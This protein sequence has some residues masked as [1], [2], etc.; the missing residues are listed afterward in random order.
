MS[1][2][3]GE[4]MTEQPEREMARLTSDLDVDV[5]VVGGGLAGLG[6]AIEAARHGA[7]VAVLE[8]RRLGYGASGCHLGTVMPGFDVPLDD[9]IAR[10]GIEN[11]SA[12]WRLSQQGADHVRALASPMPG[13]A[14]TDGALEVSNVDAG[15]R[16]I[17]RLQ[18]LGEDFGIEAIGWQIDRVRDTL[19]TGR[20]FHGVEYPRAFQ[21]DAAAYLQGLRD[22]AR[23]AGV[24]L[25]EETPVVGLDAS[26]VRKRIATPSARVRAG[27]VVLSGNVE[28]GRAFPRL[29]ATLL[30][31]WRYAALT[32][33]LGDR[34]AETIA[35]AGSVTDADGIDHFRVVGER[36]MWTSPATT[37]AGRPQRY[38]RAIQRRIRTVFP[39]LGRVAI[40]DCWSGV[41]GRTVHGMPQIGQLRQGLWVASG[42]GRQGLNTSAMAALLIARGILWRDD[43]WR[44]MSPFDL[45]WAGGRTGRV[46]GQVVDVAGRG[47]SAFAGV[48]ARHREAAK[49]RDEARE[50]RLEA[51]TQRSAAPTPPSEPQAPTAEVASSQESE[52]HA[53]APV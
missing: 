24:R 25:Y 50:A 3:A 2:P 40:Q 6:L 16:L 15:D 13:I 38:A 41:T 31:V 11:A 42:F 23:R 10:V 36:L 26:G 44:L 47:R 53:G 4:S 7:S 39:R 5:C 30:P 35:F 37:W 45:V 9:L 14:L 20:Y 19:K 43:R 49:R 1:A 34:L 21:L 51:A 46:A 48:L 32:A 22:E 18:V 52:R 28:L 12:L 17:A 33:P 8:A 27:H 29:A